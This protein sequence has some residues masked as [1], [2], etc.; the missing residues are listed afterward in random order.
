M[1]KILLLMAIILPFV[2]TSCGDDKDEPKQSLEQQLI[3]RWVDRGI[4][5]EFKADHTGI[6]SWETN[7]LT[8][9]T[10]SLE[11]NYLYMTYEGDDGEVH[12]KY[13]LKYEIAIE[14]G[15]LEISTHYNNG[16]N[17]LRYHKVQ[18]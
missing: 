4:T 10:W 5:I 18:G 1:K 13:T 7:N 14:N 3:G 16:I 9:F 17:I 11:D 12:V 2:L 15:I 8:P 6:G